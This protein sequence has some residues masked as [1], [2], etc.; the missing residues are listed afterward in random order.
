MWGYTPVG[1]TGILVYKDV[2]W[3]IIY[4]LHILTFC[5]C[6][7]ILFVG[8]ILS[9]VLINIDWLHLSSDSLVCL[10]LHG[11]ML[12]DAVDGLTSSLHQC[13]SCVSLTHSAIG[14]PV[15]SLMLSVNPASSW[16]YVRA[17]AIIITVQDVCLSSNFVR[18]ENLWSQG[19]HYYWNFIPPSTVGGTGIMFSDRPVRPSVC[20]VNTVFHKLLGRMLLNLQLW[21]TREQRWTD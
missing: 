11:W 20:L 16:S 12:D 5:S 15:Y 1:I 3:H 8:C 6:L 17:F 4:F 18:V 13:L 10:R 14:R 21:C 7:C 19:I 9:N 2:Y